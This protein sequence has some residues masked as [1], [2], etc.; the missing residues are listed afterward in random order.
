[1][2]YFVVVEDRAYP[3]DGSPPKFATLLFKLSNGLD[4]MEVCTVNELP[5][6]RFSA[7]AWRDISHSVVGGDE[8][9]SDHVPGPETR[10][11]AELLKCA[12]ATYGY[13]GKEQKLPLKDSKVGVDGAVVLGCELGSRDIDNLFD[14]HVVFD[15]EDASYSVFIAKSG[16]VCIDR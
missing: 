14:E 5:D 2:P 6:V 7:A 11:N 12:A 13:D 15:T 9:F 4:W 10:V 8:P 1:M 3:G 16:C